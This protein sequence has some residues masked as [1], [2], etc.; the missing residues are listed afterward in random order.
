MDLA[1]VRDITQ[2][3]G[4]IGCKL[5]LFC[6]SNLICDHKPERMSFT[7][8]CAGMKMIQ[9]AK[10]SMV[11][12]GRLKQDSDRFAMMQCS[13]SRGAHAK[14]MHIRCMPTLPSVLVA[15]FL[16]TLHSCLLLMLLLLLLL[17]LSCIHPLVIS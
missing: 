3:T 10:D 4:C 15:H 11:I 12:A 8:A 6:N 2:H 1:H 14:P 13:C 7:S 17:F 16:H 9:V 5:H